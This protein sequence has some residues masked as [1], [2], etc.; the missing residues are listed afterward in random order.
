MVPTHQF[1]VGSNTKPYMAVVVLQLVDE[2]VLDL[3]AP[4]ATHLAGYDEW[5]QVTLRQLLGMR[6]GVPDYLGDPQLWLVA[7]TA[8][9]TQF[10]PQELLSYVQDQPMMFPPGQGC[11]YSNSN[12]LLAGLIVEAVTG[13]KVEEELEA[14]IFEPLGLSGTFLDVKGGELEWLAGG[15]MDLDIVA[16]QFGVPASFVAMIPE[17]YFVKDLV[18]DSTYLFHPSVS[19]AAG[20]VVSRPED[21]VKFV[22]AVLEG[23]MMSD[24]ALA[25]MTDFESCS[26]LGGEVQYGL[27]LMYHATGAGPAYGH[28][29]LNFGYHANT[30]YLADHDLTFSHMRNYLPEQSGALDR[31]LVECLLAGK[32]PPTQVCHPPEGFFESPEEPVLHVRFRGLINKDK[33]EDPVG[34]VGI[35]RMESEEGPFS[36]YGYWSAAKETLSGLQKRMDIE[37]IAP[38]S[39]EGFQLRYA[40]LGADM[41]TLSGA[42]ENGDVHGKPNAPYSISAVAA[43]IRLDAQTQ[44]PDKICFRAVRD[45]SHPATIHLCDHKEFTLQAGSLLRAFA[46]VAVTTD[47]E[48]IEAYLAPLSLHLCNCPGPD[49]TLVECE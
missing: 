40:V 8:P 42:D 31:E 20:A 39:E 32:Q 24:D 47:P 44:Q 33:A 21:M 25:Q 41:V 7:F 1:R 19:W 48:A 15:Y 38:S 36:V 2:G 34:G 14:R 16:V 17:E 13:H 35:A 46:S 22:R 29:G 18:M 30:L 3:D 49:G 28:G 9:D 4:L 37:F 23:K 6:S 45:S 27:G 43:D 5:A 11:A 12:Y 10:T 26:L